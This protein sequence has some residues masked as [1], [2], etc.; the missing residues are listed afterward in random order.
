[1]AGNLRDVVAPLGTLV[2]NIT[3]LE[4]VIGYLLSNDQESKLYFSEFSPD[5]R[6]LDILT[7]WGAMNKISFELRSNKLLATRS[8]A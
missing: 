6:Q 2:P 3:T 8:N 7:S 4:D 1:M 5:K